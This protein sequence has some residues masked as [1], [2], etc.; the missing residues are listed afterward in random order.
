MAASDEHGLEIIP[1]GEVQR[2]G[3]QI[4]NHP[5][6][7]G[8]VVIAIEPEPPGEVRLRGS[9]LFDVGFGTRLF[10]RHHIDVIARHVLWLLGGM[11][12]AWGMDQAVVPQEWATERLPGGLPSWQGRLSLTGI[13][14]ED[15]ERTWSV[16]LTEW[17]S[18]PEDG[19]GARD[20]EYPAEP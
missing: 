11:S 15:R 2:F 4:L 12:T 13:D 16:P 20:E 3:V 7:E 6:R 19:V 10:R 8:D 1:V 5:L 9:I 18:A 14:D 17:E